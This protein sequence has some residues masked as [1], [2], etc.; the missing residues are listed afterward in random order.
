MQMSFPRKHHDQTSLI[1]DNIYMIYYIDIFLK[2]VRPRV[3]HKYT[4]GGSMQNSLTS[5]FWFWICTFS[6]REKAMAYYQIMMGNCIQHVL[7]R[8]LLSCLPHH[9]MLHIKQASKYCDNILAQW[10]IFVEKIA[11]CSSIC[12]TEIF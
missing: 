8:K 10:T 11:R 6:G 12:F 2:I 9:Y 5:A 3:Y 7:N 1:Q 4:N